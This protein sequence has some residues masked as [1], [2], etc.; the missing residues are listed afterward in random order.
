MHPIRG[1]RTLNSPTGGRCWRGVKN[2]LGVNTLPVGVA[3]NFRPKIRLDRVRGN[4]IIQQHYIVIVLLCRKPRPL[5][6]VLRSG[7]YLIAGH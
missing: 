1:V 6:S 5:P 4:G 3:D 2:V 7:L